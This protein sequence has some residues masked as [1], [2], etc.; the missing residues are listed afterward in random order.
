MSSVK[1]SEVVRSTVAD[2]LTRLARRDPHPGL[3]TE[4]SRL[5]AIVEGRGACH[6]PDGTVRLIRSS[7][8]VFA[9]EVRA[10]LAGTCNESV[11]GGGQ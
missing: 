3:A 1:S 8:T 5:C 4:V 11:R 10:H 7:L 2:T 9:D 6:H